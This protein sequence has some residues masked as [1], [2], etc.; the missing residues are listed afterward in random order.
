MRLTAL[1]VTADELAPVGSREVWD[2][3]SLYRSMLRWGRG[4]VVTATGRPPLPTALRRTVRRASRVGDIVPSWQASSPRRWLRDHGQ[5]ERIEVPQGTEVLY[6]HIAFPQTR[7]ALPVVWSTNGV[8]DAR[9]GIWFPDQSARTHKRFVSSAAAVQVWTRFG[10]AGLLDRW[11][12]LPLDRVHVIPPL[13]HVDLPPPWP[14]ADVEPVAVFIGAFGHLKGLDIVVDAASR[15]P[16][17]RFEIITAS[18]PPPTL[19]PNVAW[20][21]PRARAEVL[22]RLCSATVHV[23]PSTTESFG[24]VIVEALAAGVAQVVDAGSVTAEVAGDAALAIDGRD[25]EAVA[26]AVASLA[27][28]DALRRTCA[29]AGVARY[30]ATYSPEAVG[31]QLEL[32]IDAV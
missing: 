13:L 4:Q 10:L 8:I 31:A 21:G 18:P 5:V 24:S 27:G 32:V 28:D 23:C 6:G 25:V 29:A 26:A 15:L 20:L 11:P 12:G 16:Q 22:A 3:A 9:P 1:P 17:V 14:R 30:K 2:R 19:S 7:P